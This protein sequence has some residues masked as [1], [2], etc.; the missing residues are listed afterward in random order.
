MDFRAEIDVVL[1]NESAALTDVG[2]PC[3]KTLGAVMHMHSEILDF[4]GQ[5]STIRLPDF[6]L[7]LDVAD[8]ENGICDLTQLPL[9]RLVLAFVTC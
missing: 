2:F 8:P 1:G 4:C 7:L 6:E 5:V 3:V 9:T